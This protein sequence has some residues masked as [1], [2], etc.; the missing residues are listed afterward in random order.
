VVGQR[1]ARAH[2]QQTRGVARLGGPQGDA[3]LGEV[4]VEIG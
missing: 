1:L 4:E 3:I 2:D